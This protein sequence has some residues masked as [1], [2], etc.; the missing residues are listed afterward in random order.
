MNNEFADKVVVVSGSS[1]GIGHGIARAF[2]RQGAQTVLAARGPFDAATATI[3]EDGSL[4]PVTCA[5]D[6]RTPEGC[7]QVLALVSERFGRCDILVNS[8]G[9]TRAGAF[10]DLDEDAWQDGFALKFFACSRLCRLFWPLLAA[11]EGHVVN[12]VGGAART[13]DPEFLIG[14]AV[15]AAMANFSKGLSKLGKRDK[16]NVNAIYP[17]LTETERVEQLFQQRAEATG[18]TPQEVRDE[19]VV[20]EGLHRLGKPE[21]VAA[22]TLFLCSQSARHIQ[23]TS[24]AVDGGATACLF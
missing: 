20:N 19:A 4:A 9:A 1:R 11:A 10:L 23:G 14:G 3:V 16:V 2:A 15:N 8:A 18:K 12:I 21:D 5:G 6:L 7:A 17:G 24:I 13:P 22:L